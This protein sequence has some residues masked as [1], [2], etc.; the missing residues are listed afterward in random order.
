MKKA[1]IEMSTTPENK[2]KLQELARKE[3]LTLTSY[4]VLKGLNKLR[5]SK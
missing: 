4:L 5:E 3:G 2:Q 1:R